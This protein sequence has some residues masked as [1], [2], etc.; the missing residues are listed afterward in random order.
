[1]LPVLAQRGLQALAVLVQQVQLALKGQRVQVLTEPR[2]LQALAAL[3]P[4]VQQVQPAQELPEPQA[5][6][7]L[8][9][10]QAFKVPLVLA[11]RGR[12]AYKVPLEL[13]ESLEPLA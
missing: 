2:E 6:K 4:P 7:A 3:V 12:R 1:M 13:P 10:Q 8:L 11:S 9:E 5:P